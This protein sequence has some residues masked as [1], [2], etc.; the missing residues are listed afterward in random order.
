MTG[1]L[2]AELHE[3]VIAVDRP[4]VASAQVELNGRGI[5]ARG[6][7]RS[8]QVA[9]GLAPRAAG[10]TLLGDGLAEIHAGWIGV[11]ERRRVCLRAR[12]PR[13]SSLHRQPRRYTSHDRRLDASYA[14]ILAVGPEGQIAGLARIKEADLHIVPVLLVQR[15]VPLEAVVEE[16][17]LPAD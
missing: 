3:G 8:E 12:I 1:M 5:G 11:D 10:T 9:D 13:G 16:L 7:G 14:E 15:A 17:G 2:T 6:S 4:V